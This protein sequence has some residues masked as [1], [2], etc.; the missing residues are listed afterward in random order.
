MKSSIDV[1]NPTTET[2]GKELSD[3]QRDELPLPSDP[4]TVLLA[5]LFMFTV[6]TAAYVAAEVVLPV[7]LAIILKLLLQPGVRLLWRLRIPKSLS[8]LLV[9]VAMISTILAIGAAV[10][11]P[12]KTW[13]DHLPE[14]LPRI[15]E[16]LRFLRQPIAS[17]QNALRKADTMGQSDPAPSAAPS[18]G[19]SATLFSGTQHFASGLFETL[20]ILFFL[21]SSGDTFLR[22]LVEIMPTFK[23]KRQVVDLSQQVEDNISAYLVI[24]TLMNA[25]VGFATAI[26]MWACGVGEPVLWG[27]VAFLLNYIPIIGPFAGIVIFLVAGLLAIPSFGLALLPAGLYFLVHVVEGETVTPMLLA[28]RFTLNPVLVILALIFWFWMWGVPG[29][30]LSVPMLAIAKIICDGVKPLNS[31]GH[32][33]EGEAAA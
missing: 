12:A 2:V 14:G 21:L 9:I 29:A 28:R 10:S 1:T 33:M 23:D 7:V 19:L 31:I 18:L 22:R 13:V 3:P 17:L 30:I 25:A 27:V 8:A 11:T 24:V 32:F 26:I 16:R 15:E 6:L 5:G 4:K 20:L